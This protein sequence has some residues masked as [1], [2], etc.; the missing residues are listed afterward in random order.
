MYDDN[1]NKQEQ[2]PRSSTYAASFLTSLL[3]FPFAFPGKSNPEV[4]GLAVLYA[5]GAVG[6][7]GKGKVLVL[8]CSF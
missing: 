6:D 7:G 2:V 4:G 8:L 1:A 3:L 5:P